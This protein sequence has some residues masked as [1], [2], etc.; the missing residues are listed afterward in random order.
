[1]KILIAANPD[2]TH[3]RK[4]V[5][6]LH[7]RGIE[8][9]LFSLTRFDTEYYQSFQGLRWYCMKDAASLAKRDTRWGKLSYLSSIG[10]LKRI[11]RAEQ[12]DILHA[13]YASSYGFVAALSG[14]H[15]LIVSVWGS[16]VFEFPTRSVLSRKMLRYTFRKADVVL[17]TSHI[18]AT[19]TAKYTNKAVQVTPF[20]IDTSVFK[21]TG[22]RF[23]FAPTD[24]VIGSIKA[25]EPVYGQAV[26]LRAF[27]QLL[28]SHPNVPL[29]LLIVGEGSL[30]A[31]LE[32]TAT[33]LGVMDDTLFVGHVGHHQIVEYFSSIDIF[34]VSSFQESFGVSALEAA[35]C[36]LPVIASR[37]GGL[38]EVVVDGQSGL[39]IDTG[40]VDAL[41]LALGS[42]I[43][44]APRRKAMG[45][46]GRDFVQRQYEWAS[47]VDRM[48]GIYTNILKK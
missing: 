13:H 10:K 6:S 26:L 11:L 20:G 15:P 7:E 17:S 1:M 9:V 44:D 3:T 46:A 21:H 41:A 25:L 34:V 48:M 14:F 33:R 30:R 12:P 27:A 16:D 38:P 8:I 18:M 43:D 31:Q 22:N 19:E 28:S 23:V 40:N 29:K 37:V 36:E 2:S 47:C 39:L 35:S 5:K 4:W 45:A 42:L 24:V 32:A